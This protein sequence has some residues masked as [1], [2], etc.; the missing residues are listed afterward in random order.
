VGTGD[1][2]GDWI[3]EDSAFL[4]NTSDG[5]DL[6]YHSLGGRIVLD[7]VHAE[8]NAGNQVKVAGQLA[9]TN[10]LLVA[11]APFSKASRSPTT[12]I[13]AGR[14]ATRWRLPTPAGN[15][16]R[17]SI[18]PSMA[19]AMACWRRPARRLY[20]DGSEALAVRNSVFLGDDEYLSLRHHLPFLPGGLPRP[21]ARF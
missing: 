21:E 5:L 19:R 13:R 16:Y 15:R 14:W 17:S 11:I 7:G 6:L 12:S 9:I 2:G 20:C 4:H 8:G 10:S 18:R 1:T 3:I